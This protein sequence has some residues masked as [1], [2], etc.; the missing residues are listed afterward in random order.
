MDFRKKSEPDCGCEDP[1]CCQPKR[2]PKWTLVLSMLIILGAL[3]IIVIR[4]AG[5]EKKEAGSASGSA[6]CC[7]TTDKNC[8]DTANTKPCC[9]KAGN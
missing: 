8:C 9:T 3:S 6:A 2:R 5:D 7:D 4:L 1:D